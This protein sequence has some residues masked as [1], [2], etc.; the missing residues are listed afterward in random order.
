MNR[1][2]RLVHTSLL[3]VA[4]LCA[5]GLASAEKAGPP[6]CDERTGSIGY[7]GTSSVYEA[8]DGNGAFRLTKVTPGAPAARAGLKPG[9]VVVAIDGHPLPADRFEFAFAARYRRPGDV[10]RHTV[11]RGDETLSLDVTLAEPPDGWEE[12]YLRSLQHQETERRGEGRERLGRL[13]GPSEVT[14]RRDLRCR[15]VAEHDG[16]PMPNPLT[17][18]AGLRIVPLLERLHPGDSVSL[19]VHVSGNSLRLDVADFPSYLT[20]R[21]LNAAVQ[22]TVQRDQAHFH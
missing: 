22:E 4:I 12:G 6:A 10:I 5:G 1:R 21:D 3:L 18:A 13:N 16:R 20:K 19:E 15:F 14:F 11:R 17:L 9:D 2:P 7:L 8:T